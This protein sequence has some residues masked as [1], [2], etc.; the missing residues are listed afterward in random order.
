MD[1]QVARYLSSI[2]AASL[3]WP[4]AD[5]GLAR[6][7]HRLRV[8]SLVLWGEQDRLAPPALA[9]R[10]P[11]ERTVVVPDA[12]HLLEWDAPDQ[13]AAEITKFLHP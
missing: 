10:W 8:P 9:G 12:G 4:I 1:R 2:A 6:R 3:V 13:V 5:H 11:A 7:I